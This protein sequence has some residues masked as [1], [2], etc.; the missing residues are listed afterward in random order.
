MSEQCALCTDAEAT[1]RLENPAVLGSWF[2]QESRIDVLYGDVVIPLCDGCRERVD[3]A[4]AE[5][6]DARGL[7]AKQAA[8]RQLTSLAERM[9]ASIVEAVST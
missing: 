6:K 9:N 8:E 1:T 4:L 5:R 7:D 2:V 3:N